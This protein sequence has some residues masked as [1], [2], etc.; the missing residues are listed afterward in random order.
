ML[1]AE[2]VVQH[3]LL[4]R[5]LFAKSKPPVCIALCAENGLTGGSAESGKVLDFVRI[6]IQ[7]TIRFVSSLSLQTVQTRY[8]KTVA[9]CF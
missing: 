4:C 6:P 8:Y 2:R 1:M 7:P 5:E 3:S 9:S